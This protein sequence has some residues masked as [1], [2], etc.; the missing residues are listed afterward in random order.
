MIIECCY[1]ERSYM[2]FYGLMAQRF[3]EI[4]REYQQTFEEAFAYQVRP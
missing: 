1:N 2:K 4:K 3:C